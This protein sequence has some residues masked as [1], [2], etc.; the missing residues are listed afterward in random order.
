VDSFNEYSKNNNLDI[1]LKLNLLT[2][3]NFSISVENSNMMFE[4]LL[5]NKRNNYDLYIYDAS[6]TKHYCKYFVDLSEHLGKEH[7]NAFNKKIISQLSLCEDKLIGM[8]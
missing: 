3:N 4:S 8:V 5:N 2:T 1:N 7:V 6:W